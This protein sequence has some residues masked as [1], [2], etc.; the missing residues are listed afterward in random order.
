MQIKEKSHPNYNCSL[1]SGINL[2]SDYSTIKCKKIGNYILSKTIGKG[3]FSKVKLGHHIPTQQKVAIKILD[4]AKIKDDKDLQRI[5][6]EIKI[7]KEL[8][9]NNIAQLYETLTSDRHIYIIMEYIEGGDLF[10]HI[11]SKTRLNEAKTAALFNQLISVIDYIHKLGIVHRDIKP[12]NILLTATHSEIKLV[13]FGLSNS[14]QQGSLLS[15]ACGSPCYASPEM[16]LG[17]QY[18]GLSSDLWSCGVVLYCMLVGKLPFDD[19]DIKVLY[20]K[21]ITGSYWVPDY[22]SPQCNHFLNH[23]LEINPDK[24]MTIHEIFNHP[25]IASNS[26]QFIDR[27]III[28]TD[29]IKIDFGLVK[30]IKDLYCPSNKNITEKTIVSYLQSNNHNNITTMYYLALN[31]KKKQLKAQLSQMKIERKKCE[32]FNKT[33]IKKIHF[34]NE[35]PKE[36]QKDKQIQ[37]PKVNK[38]PNKEMNFVVINNFLSEN[39]QKKNVN[40]N[41]SINK[42]NITLNKNT[43]NYN[44]NNNNIQLMHT[45]NHTE[46]D[47]ILNTPL[48]SFSLNSNMTSESNQ[49]KSIHEVNV[50]LCKRN[51]TKPNSNTLS[52]SLGKTIKDNSSSNNANSSLNHNAY[53]LT[54][55]YDRR[56]KHQP[57]SR[58]LKPN[59]QSKKTPIR[60]RHNQ[61][62]TSLPNNKV[63]IA[64]L[65]NDFKEILTKYRNKSQGKEDENEKEDGKRL[66][67]SSPHSHLNKRIATCNTDK[68]LLM[69]KI[70]NNED[71]TGIDGLNNNVNT[72][73]VNNK[74]PHPNQKNIKSTLPEA[75]PRLNSKTVLFIHSFR[76]RIE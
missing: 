22:L 24:R 9:H 6:R 13:D 49:N 31:Q 73:F 75:N 4:K 43:N 40:M 26:A 8:R 58:S 25:F 44:N 2:N 70:F 69:R 46:A 57:V 56:I 12:E 45:R 19:E 52:N 11:F 17:K 71:R 16:I 51:K 37:K 74:I 15:T 76:S 3:T 55:N 39:N 60:H 65:K 29:E 21:I 66:T 41:I 7:L 47:Q 28:G 54:Y 64:K 33:N 18:N 48:L 72:T 35:K 67:F 23:L 20:R 27:G 53:Q 59:E 10:E 36:K 61:Q 68:R 34:E 30:E 14:Y 1:T 50:G 38:E 42:A 63:E 62:K 5:S 32:M